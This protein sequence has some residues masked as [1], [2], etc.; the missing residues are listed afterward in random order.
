MEQNLKIYTGNAAK[1]L[2]FL[3][4]GCTPVQAASATGVSIGY[5]SQLCAEPDFQ[6]QIAQKLQQDFEKA[7]E[8]DKNYDEVEYLLS[9]KLK[10]LAPMMLG[11]DDILKS[12]KVVNSLKK[13]TAP[14]INA[15]QENT[16]NSAKPVTL[17]LP[18]VVVNNFI[19]NPNSEVVEVDG[20]NLVTLNS[21]SIDSLARKVIEEEVSDIQNEPIPKLKYSPSEV[22]NAQS[23][24]KWGNL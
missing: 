4:G 1:V 20:L 18:S 17:V 6:A 23:K 21:N 22:V 14:S 5:V 24:D 8:T 2:N 16:G 3:K 13:K 15:G 7:I 19:M 11:L 12:I 10:Q 9:Q